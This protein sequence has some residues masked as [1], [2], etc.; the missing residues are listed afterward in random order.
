MLPTLSGLRWIGWGCSQIVRQTARKAFP[1]SHL[2]WAWEGLSMFS[3]VT[4]LCGFWKG[5]FCLLVFHFS[6]HYSCWSGLGSIH[7]PAPV[8]LIDHNLCLVLLSTIQLWQQRQRI[9]VHIV[10]VHQEDYTMTQH[11]RQQPVSLQYCMRSVFD[12]CSSTPDSAVTPF[13]KAAFKSL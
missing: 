9:S 1:T 5:P 7:H 13:C 10:G 12:I 6:V 8:V 11:R 4:T 2:L 3:P